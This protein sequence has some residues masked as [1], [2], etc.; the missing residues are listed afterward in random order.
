[1]AGQLFTSVYESCRNYVGSFRPAPPSSVVSTTVPG[2]WSGLGP[3][4]TLGSPVST[5]GDL[6]TGSYSSPTD[7]KGPGD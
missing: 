6:R 1:M 7:P 2:L 3:L 5:P 4:W